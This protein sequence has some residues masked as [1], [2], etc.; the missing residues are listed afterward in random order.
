MERFKGVNEIS[1]EAGD[2]EDLLKKNE[3]LDIQDFV[4]EAKQKDIEQ[5]QKNAEQ[6]ARMKKFKGG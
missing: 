3:Y 1:I 4:Q 5:A 2:M 6:A